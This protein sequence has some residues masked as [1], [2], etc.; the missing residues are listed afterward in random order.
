MQV[1]GIDA[2]RDP[3][4][5]ANALGIS[6]EAVELHATSD[7]IDLHLDSFIWTRLLG[8]DLT[9]RHGLGPLRGR[10][11][12]QADLPRAI[13]GGLTGATWSITT[14]VLANGDERVDNLVANVARLRSIL[15]STGDARVVRDW[16]EYKAARR[17][18]LHAAFVGIQGGNA[19]DRAPHD[20]ER[21]ADGTILRVTLLH[22]TNSS[23]GT[24]SSPLAGS[25]DG[26][27]TT[28]GRDF[29]QGLN[30]QK[31]FV[32][33]AHVSRRTFWDT[34]GVH[35]RS[36]P[37]IA[38]HT[39]V[40]GVMKHW[41]NLDDDQ[42]RAIA[43]TGGTIGVMLMARFLGKRRE[44]NSDTVVHHLAHIV[45]TVGEDHASIG[46]DYDGW[47]RPPGDLPSCAELPRL[48]HAM[49]KRGWTPQRVRKVLGGN[50]LRTLRELR[51]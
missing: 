29:V 21:L 10:W 24:T 49:L 46:T 23:I 31:V 36:Q 39:G 37:L 27:L 19:L 51:G 28:R 40:S 22:L 13:E 25:T 20:I 43:D 11:F 45:E 17:A 38:T 2:Q 33:L 18:G 48:T 4:A 35:D 14:N 6:R 41:R 12:H 26:G 3:Q 9:R 1:E 44:V 47:I 32:D 15:E 8:Y 5:R 42:L 34:L 7:V 50:F 16:A 30:A